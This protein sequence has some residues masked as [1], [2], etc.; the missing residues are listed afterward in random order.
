M[1]H[2]V[3]ALFC[4]ASLA[5]A[6]EE[7]LL[8]ASINA[9]LPKIKAGMT[10]EEIKAVVVKSYAKA[11]SRV[12]P[13]SGVTGSLGCRLD[14]RFSF[15]IAAHTN[16]EGKQIVSEDARIYIYDWKH[17]R[18]LEIVPYRWEGG[19]KVVPPAK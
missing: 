16:N 15:E 6:E 7:P 3:L 4:F 8:P 18:R 19:S 1:K 2:F 9:F 11:E 5:F 17:K 12:G 13:W 10:S 14:D